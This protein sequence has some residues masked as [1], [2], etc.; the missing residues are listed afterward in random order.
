MIQRNGKR[1]TA[2][3]WAA[4]M[5]YWDIDLLTDFYYER[6]AEEYKVMTEAEQD[7]VT[8]HIDAYHKRILK[9]VEKIRGESA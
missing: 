2:K 5:I 9:M 6:H 7:Q 4:D 8:R 1:V 3:Q